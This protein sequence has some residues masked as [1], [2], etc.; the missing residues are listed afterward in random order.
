MCG[1]ARRA[2]A[3]TCDRGRRPP[4]APPGPGGPSVATPH[5]VGGETGHAGRCSPPDDDVAPFAAERR[6]NRAGLV[7]GGFGG[8]VERV[9]SNPVA[10]YESV[11][12]Y[13]EPCELPGPGPTSVLFLREDDRLASYGKVAPLA[14]CFVDLFNTPGWQAA[15]F[16]EW[17]SVKLMDA[18]V[19]TPHGC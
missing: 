11:F 7:I 3:P 10:T 19:I 17:T 4:T 2:E 12:A 1:L 8:L 13:G 15:R 6:L 5:P 9:G 18:D 14:Q 16:V